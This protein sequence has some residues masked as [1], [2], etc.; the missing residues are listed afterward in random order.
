MADP[1][2]SRCRSTPASYCH[3][4]FN[5]ISIPSCCY[6]VAVQKVPYRKYWFRKPTKNDMTLQFPC[7][8]IITTEN[9][10]PATVTLRLL[11]TPDTNLA[12]TTEEHNNVHAKNRSDGR[13]SVHWRSRALNIGRAGAPAPEPPDRA[14]ARSA[15]DR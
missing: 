8:G 13:P 12:C 11:T 6:S 10:S 5:T 14:R 1:A 4:G 3:A 2:S 9:S 15:V 7:Q